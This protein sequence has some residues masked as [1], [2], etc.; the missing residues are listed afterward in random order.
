[1]Q[2]RN[3]PVDEPF[4]PDE[5]DDFDDGDELVVDVADPQ[6]V[7]SRAITP[8]ATPFLII[9]RTRY[10]LV[11]GSPSAARRTA[12]TNPPGLCEG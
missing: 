2:P 6:A 4:E 5:V 12:R 9:P 7:A 3:L 11:M 8:T 1:M 10:L